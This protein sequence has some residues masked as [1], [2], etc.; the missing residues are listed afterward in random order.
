MVSLN[1]L[2]EDVCIT[3]NVVG[4]HFG[5]SL[6]VAVHSGIFAVA[7]IAELFF[8]DRDRSDRSNDMETSLK[9]LASSLRG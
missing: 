5:K 7:T 4:R 2:Q 1:F 9:L 6:E 8:Y 3:E